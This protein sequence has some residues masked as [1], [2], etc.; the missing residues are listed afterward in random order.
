MS[1]LIGSLALLVALAYLRGTP[2]GSL[3]RAGLVVRRA[4]RRG[5]R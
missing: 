4:V 3:L 5:Q 2:S 1:H